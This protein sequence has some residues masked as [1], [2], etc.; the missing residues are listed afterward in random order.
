[1][2]VIYLQDDDGLDLIEEYHTLAAA[3]YHAERLVNRGY[4]LLQIRY[5]KPWR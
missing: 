1:M 4:R 2:Y 3:E 5:E